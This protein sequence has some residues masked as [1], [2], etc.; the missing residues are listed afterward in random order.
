MAYEHLGL[1]PFAEPTPV[2]P[3]GS[4]GDSCAAELLLAE[5]VPLVEPE[6]EPA[7]ELGELAGV[8]W[9]SETAAASPVTNALECAGAVGR[10]DARLRC[11]WCRAVV[12]ARL[13]PFRVPVRSCVSRAWWVL[14]VV[15]VSRYRVLSALASVIY[16]S[17]QPGP[18]GAGRR[19]GRVAR[20]PS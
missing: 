12:A 4:L 8:D 7:P 9:V 3:G 10:V 20:R 6:P 11:V 14:V 19:A 15:R 17:G 2:G 5:A 16:P 1:H 13:A 18:L